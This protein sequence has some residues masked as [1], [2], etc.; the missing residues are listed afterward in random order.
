MEALLRRGSVQAALERLQQEAQEATDA[1]QDREIDEHAHLI[2]LP[3]SLAG[4]ATRV[5][6]I[7]A[8]LE[9]AGL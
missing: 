1:A 6:N 7:E 3:A 8:R 5:G 9:A 4:L 2:A